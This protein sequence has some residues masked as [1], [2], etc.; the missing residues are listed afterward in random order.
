MLQHAVKTSP[1]AL[2]FCFVLFLVIIMGVHDA[3]LAPSFEHSQRSE[4]NAAGSRSMERKSS[5]ADGS[6]AWTGVIA[7]G[8]MIVIIA[9]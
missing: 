6:L 7:V 8:A 9:L 1:R 5:I 2:L 4:G 3:T